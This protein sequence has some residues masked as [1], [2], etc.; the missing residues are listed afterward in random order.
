MGNTTENDITIKFNAI[1]MVNI[2]NVSVVVLSMKQLMSKAQTHIGKMVHC[3][4][5]TVLYQV[6]PQ[7]AAK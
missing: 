5:Q 1:I 4:V 3:L 2:H 6:I 7:I